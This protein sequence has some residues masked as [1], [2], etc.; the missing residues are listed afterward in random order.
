MPV[1]EELVAFNRNDEEVA[2]EI[3]ADKIIYQDLDDLIEACH[4]ENPAITEF[5]TSCFS[6]EYVTSGVSKEYLESIETQ[7]NDAN[8]ASNS[9]SI[10]D[11]ADLTGY[12]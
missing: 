9:Q 4:E 3:G 12:M 5:D 2:D 10:L 8:K 6:G 11:L 1:A 7:R